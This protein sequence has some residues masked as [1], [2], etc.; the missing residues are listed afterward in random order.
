MIDGFTYQAVDVCLVDNTLHTDRYFNKIKELKVKGKN[1]ITWRHE[2]DI[3]KQH[4]LQMLADVREEIRKYFLEHDY[5]YIFWLDDDVFIPAN[6]IQKLL[7]YNKEQVGFIVPVFYKP[8]RVPCIFKSTEIVIGKGMC[9]YSW[10]E[11]RAYKRFVKQMASNKMTDEEK[12]LIPFIVKDPW[13]PQLIKCAAVNLG[14]LMVKKDVAKAVPFR[15]HPTFVWGEDCWY[16]TEA[17]A[18]KFEFWA[19]TSV[20]VIHKNTDWNLIR[21]QGREIG[22]NVA[23][24]TVDAK[25][26]DIIYRGKE[27]LPLME[28]K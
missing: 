2:W 28:K 25:G 23:I 11:I 17:E 21:K 26:I 1:V 10:K 20:K 7:S 18:K 9:Y 22:F 27:K 14:C 19:D 6:S 15:T 8:T 3:K 4:P 16:F 5:D 12:L 24:G 13:H